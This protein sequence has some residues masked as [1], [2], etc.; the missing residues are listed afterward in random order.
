MILR[1][2]NLDT[3]PTL[4]TASVQTC[5]T[6]P[7][8]YA[9]RDYG[10]PPSRWPAIAYVPLHGM[11]PIEIPA[12]EVCLG[13][14]PSPAA[15]IGHLVH[16][17]REVHR[18][19]KPDGTLWMNLGDSYNSGTNANQRPSQSAN[20]GS[21]PRDRPARGNAVNLSPKNLM[22]LPWRAALALQADGWILRQDVIWHKKTPMPETVSDRPTR[23]HEYLF[24]FA[25]QRY[26]HYDASAIAEP[27]SED[28][29]ARY[30]QPTPPKGRSGLY[31]EHPEILPRTAERAARAERKA[32]KVPSGWDTSEGDHRA[33]DGRYPRVKNNPSFDAAMG[34]AGYMPTTRNKRS[35]WTLGPEPYAGAHFATF[36]ESLVEPCI[37][38]SSRP[39]DLVLDPFGGSG[40][41]G[42]VA[43]RLGR[44]YVLCELKPDYAELA[45]DR[46]HHTPLGLALA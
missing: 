39:G 12:M 16:L 10:I 42:A 22:G 40:T 29:H 30:A 33:L 46:I 2:D 36:P 18:I 27:C 44:P 34:T 31:G 43:Q 20:V 45:H 23:A 41:T 5:I 26:Y 35:V 19:L 1:G 13:L 37:L 28:S 25:K 6:S 7:P 8:Y 32:E 9:L 14:E 3:L 4:A 24:L 15:F 17:F 11:D 21:P 38:A